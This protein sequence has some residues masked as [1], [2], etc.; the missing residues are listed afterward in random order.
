MTQVSRVVLI[1]VRL[2]MEEIAKREPAEA[3]DPGLY[4]AASRDAGAIRTF[5]ADDAKHGRPPKNGCW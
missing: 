1:G 5:V 2:G 4:E 3:E